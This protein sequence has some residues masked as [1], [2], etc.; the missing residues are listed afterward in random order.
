MLLNKERNKKT[1]KVTVKLC[2]K[3]TCIQCGCLDLHHVINFSF[4]DWKM[5]NTNEFVVK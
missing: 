5:K 3:K 1:D 4:H 2:K